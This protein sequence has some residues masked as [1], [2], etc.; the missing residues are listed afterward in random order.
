MRSWKTINTKD[1]FRT[2]K[3]VLTRELI[4]DG[5]DERYSTYI[6]Q[7]TPGVSIIPYTPKDRSFVLV[8]QFRNSIKNE[9][10][11]FPAGHMNEGESALECA[12]RELHEETKCSAEKIINLGNFYPDSELI[13]TKGNFFLA[14][15]PI[16]D[17]KKSNFEAEEVLCKKFREEEVIKA[18]SNGEIRDGWTLSAFCLFIIWDTDKFH[19]EQA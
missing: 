1:V 8:K 13:A 4:T 11:Q 3:I 15:N 9:I 2:K 18:I 7:I 5:S 12:K 14:L 6:T 16:E 10:W 17:L 19:N